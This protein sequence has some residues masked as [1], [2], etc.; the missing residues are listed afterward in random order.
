MKRLVFA[1]IMATSLPAFA[2]RLGAH[3]GVNSSN[4]SQTPS[5]TYTGRTGM[6]AG[7][8]LESNM[9]TFL[10][11]QIEGDYVQKG[12]SGTSLNY[13]EFPVLLRLNLPF[14]VITPFA[15]AGPSLGFLSSA[16]VGPLDVKSSYASTDW[17]LIFG[18]G[19]ELAMGPVAA[20]IVQL[21]YQLGLSDIDPTA[22]FTT[23]NNGF[24]VTGG[25]LFGF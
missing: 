16:S 6:I 5:V 2:L 22:A 19:V 9:G 18:G 8:I 13:L 4:V 24:Q 14:P 3:G 7:A 10:S 25:F 20:L 15:M 12:T 23:K 1:L 17:G 21:R 11:L